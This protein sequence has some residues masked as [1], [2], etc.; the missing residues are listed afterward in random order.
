M[1]FVIERKSNTTTIDVTIVGRLV[2][3]LD[4]SNTEKSPWMNH[5]Q[6][7]VQEIKQSD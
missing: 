2:T 5:M 7:K 1:F 6:K 3:I 4:G